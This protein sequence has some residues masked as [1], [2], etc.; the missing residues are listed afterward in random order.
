MK[1]CKRLSGHYSE[2]CAFAMYLLLSIF[3]FILLAAGS[4]PAYAQ[5]STIPRRA[6]MSAMEGSVLVQAA[7]Q[8]VAVPARKNMEIKNG[9]RVITGNDGTCE[10]KYD[11]GS[12][13]RI[14]PNSRVD[15][16]ALSRTGADGSETTV[17]NVKRGSIWNNTKQVV[18]RNS[19]FEVNTPAAAASVR[20][21]QFYINV[22]SFLDT[23]VRVY[24]GLVG[25]ASAPEDQQEDVGD[26]GDSA[27]PPPPPSG[28]ETAVSAFQQ[29]LF[30]T[31]APPAPP[32]PLD[33][34]AVD[35]FEK[36]NLVEDF[37]SAY[38]EIETEVKTYQLQQTELKVLGELKNLV[39]ITQELE[40]LKQQLERETDP[41]KISQLQSLQQQLQIE[42]ESRLEMA[43][44]LEKERQQLAQEK[45]KLAELK[46]KMDT[47]TPEQVKEEAKAVRQEEKAKAAER[48][49]R[50]EQITK[51]EQAVTEIREQVTKQAEEIGVQETLQ[52]AAEKVTVE[53]IRQLAEEVLPEGLQTEEKEQ[54]KEEE[55]KE[56]EEK[57]PTP[58]ATGG[59]GGGG[60]GGA[61]PVSYTLTVSASPEDAGTVSGGGSFTSGSNVT[62]S[63]TANSGYSFVNWTEGGAVVSSEA[64]YSFVLSG[65]RTL[66]ANFVVKIPDTPEVTTWPTAS[67][68]VYGQPL[69]DAVLIGGEASVFGTFAFA[70]PS[71][72]PD[73]GSTLQAVVFTP[74]DTVNYKTVIGNVT[75]IVNKAPATVTLEDLEHTYDGT[76]KTAKVITNPSGLN[77]TI[78]YNGSPEAPVTAGSYVVEATIADANYTGTTKGTL[79]I[80]KATPSVSTWPLASELVYGQTLADA[81]LSGGEASVPGTFAFASPSMIPSAGTALQEVIFLPSDTVNYNEVKGTTEVT[82]KQSAATITLEDLEHTYDGTPKT[83]TVVT[84]PSGLNVTITYNGSTEAPVNA[85]EYE[86]EATIA[87]AN[88]TGTATGTL[89]INE[90]TPAIIAAS[91]F[92]YKTDYGEGV[93]IIRNSTFET[94]EIYFTLN[95]DLP[96]G[97]PREITLSF[98]R[99]AFNQEATT[100]EIYMDIDGE[101]QSVAYN[102]IS[103]GT[104]DENKDSVVKITIPEGVNLAAGE[105][106]I[107]GGFDYFAFTT[108]DV[109][110]GTFKIEIDGASPLECP[111]YMSSIS[112]AR[113]YTTGLEYDPLFNNCSAPQD[114]IAS[115]EPGTN[116]TAETDKTITIS[117]PYVE[118]DPAANWSVT[119]DEGQPVSGLTI[120]SITRGDIGSGANAVITLSLAAGSSLKK[121]TEYL[122]SG[123]NVILKTADVEG[124][125]LYVQLEG[126]APHPESFRMEEKTWPGNFTVEPI[127][128]LS[129]IT[130]T[131]TLTYTP[132]EA[133]DFLEVSI[134]FEIGVLGT[135]LIKIGSGDE[136]TLAE[137]SKAE[138]NEE[139]GYLYLTFEPPLGPEDSIIITLLDKPM[140]VAGYYEFEIWACAGEKFPSMEIAAIEVIDGQGNPAPPPSVVLDLTTIPQ[141]TGLDETMEYSLDGGESW[142]AIDE[143]ETTAILDYFEILEY[144][145][146]KVRIK[147][148]PASEAHIT[149]ASIDD[150]EGEECFLNL[151][152]GDDQEWETDDDKITN[153]L[154][155]AKYAVCIFS[156]DENVYWNVYEA[157]IYGEINYPYIFDIAGA[158]KV[159]PQA[160]GTFLQIPK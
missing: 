149:V 69:A 117:I 58:P 156:S 81:V 129:G 114:G 3:I 115:F 4:V 106:E 140:P 7:G 33:A 47:L 125:D 31:D 112:S 128:A 131:I 80:G 130:Q 38:V 34:L 67:G 134:P 10:F 56:E 74:Q 138:V 55:K 99:L 113:L 152:P 52:Q 104:L 20:G 83:A 122:I 13:S 11:D 100:G 116:I 66:V 37:P 1:T 123:T 43:K 75:V 40:L 29:I 108:A 49:E 103:K 118:I 144:K 159:E 127:T 101:Y 150:G 157:D 63:A 84:N 12:V 139:Y 132:G 89:V 87:D 72:V 51:Q 19:R 95:M 18:K 160:I 158:V 96:A 126:E 5:G 110:Q 2:H 17:L 23:I 85:G 105:Y 36:D 48:E 98:S 32:A 25:L 94:P 27:S 78:T 28:Q 142:I 26:E 16:S 14:G 46:E 151:D 22:E 102:I 136:T 82:V 155:G 145:V 143:G 30:T 35:D 111:Y 15:I 137:A 121:G 68:L 44:N 90:S 135:D 91:L 65:N 61:S 133:I 6:I 109:P 77:V 153:L 41:A 50:L 92:S 93:P 154:P 86:V 120:T 119:D 9:D 42:M 21:T 146:V 124:G 88:Y 62:V 64:N 54:E 141:L 73:A 147:E 53:L 71:M 45:E 76:P 57:D 24:T 79:V 60:G 107:D 97:A 8:A 59:G 148:V 70:N 39:L